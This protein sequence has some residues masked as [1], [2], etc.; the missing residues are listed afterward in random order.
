[1]TIRRGENWGEAVAAPAGLVMVEDDAAAC[2]AVAEGCR[3]L[4]I[5]RGDLART[6]G[7]GAPGRFDGAVVRAPVDLLHV[8]ADGESCVAVAHVVIRRA[9]WRGPLVLVMNAQYL[10]PYDVAPRSHPN[11]GKA[12]VLT[13]APTMG[14]R[15]RL[16][17]RRRAVTGTHLPHPLLQTTQVAAHRV[18]LER[19]ATVWVDG[20]RWR[21][22]RVVDV[23][24]EPDGV[25]IYA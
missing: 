9:W 7:G 11:D 23:K 1:M 19:P 10:G 22:A 18:E 6:M 24:V 15:A 25:T 8:T 4:G 12:D 14:V 2:A 20:C 13:V 5:R 3:E 16:A 17:A 21:R